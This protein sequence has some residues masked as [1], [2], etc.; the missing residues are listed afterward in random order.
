MGEYIFC[1]Y[2][3]PVRFWLRPLGLAELVDAVD[4]KSIFV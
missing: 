1:T 3:I 2:E 4:L